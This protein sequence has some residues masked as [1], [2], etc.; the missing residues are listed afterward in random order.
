MD[1]GATFSIFFGVVPT[2][3]LDGAFFG[4]GQWSGICNLAV[5]IRQSTE[6]T[7]VLKHLSLGKLG[8]QI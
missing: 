8:L 1:I 6:S 2:L 7:H 5:S 3:P 4:S